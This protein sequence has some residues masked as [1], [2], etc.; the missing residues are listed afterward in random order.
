MAKSC[1]FLWACT[2]AILLAMPPNLTAQSSASTLASE[3]MVA[4][5]RM[6][7]AVN[8]DIYNGNLVA[9]LIPDPGVNSLL[10]GI[11]LDEESN[12]PVL[13]IDVLRNGPFDIRRQ[14][15]RMYA[16]QS[17]RIKASVNDVQMINVAFP[18]QFYLDPKIGRDWKLNPG[19]QLPVPQHPA[20]T[21][22]FPPFGV[23]DINL[24]LRELLSTPLVTASAKLNQE[25]KRELDM[26][27]EARKVW[28]QLHFSERVINNPPLYL[29]CRPHEIGLDVDRY[30]SS[31][32]VAKV[33]AMVTLSLSDVPEEDLTPTE[34][35][36]N[37]LENPSSGIQLTVPVTLSEALIQAELNKRLTNVKKLVR[38]RSAASRRPVKP[39][40]G[41]VRPVINQVISSSNLNMINFKAQV[42]EFEGFEVDLRGGYILGTATFA[43]SFQVGGKMERVEG[44][45]S[46]KFRVSNFKNVLKVTAY[47]PHVRTNIR[48]AGIELNTLTQE[49]MERA[50]GAMQ[51][52]VSIPY[53]R[54]KEQAVDTINSRIDSMPLGEGIEFQG[55]IHSMGIDQI[56]IQEDGLR[57]S[58]K[59]DGE[60]V[61]LVQ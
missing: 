9:D 24:F 19:I 46:L 20:L 13:D 18:L 27:G 49:L 11:R 16:T 17:V 36:L 52:S 38:Q 45:L 33:G 31:S 21:F 54:E 58:V 44:R 22:S 37:G 7:Q 15:G 61:V 57:V 39:A 6:E 30:T 1:H 4:Y 8:F 14:G 35:P 2:T 60:S 23:I 3:V 55:T 5:T 12:F 48:L 29:T 34:V 40:A 41:A 51:L 26:K 50:E 25:L 42:P 43:H 10:K 53:E 56:L 47:D 59:A 28:N 32:M